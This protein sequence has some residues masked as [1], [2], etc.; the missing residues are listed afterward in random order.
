MHVAGCQEK[1][2]ELF[3]VKL[4]RQTQGP[5]PGKSKLDDRK[6][7]ILELREIGVTK[8]RIAEK[9]GTTVGN[10]NH[11]IKKRNL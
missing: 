3:S 11:W 5:G 7:E 2:S 8:K 6:D 1:K 9:M 10:L 4:R